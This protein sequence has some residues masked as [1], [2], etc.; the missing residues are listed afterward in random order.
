MIE[1]S[2][3][4]GLTSTRVFIINQNGETKILKPGDK[5][6]LGY[7]QQIDVENRE[8]IFNLDKGGIKEIFTLKVER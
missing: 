8:V 1:Q 6:Y 2:R 7:L 5:V 4:I 3:L